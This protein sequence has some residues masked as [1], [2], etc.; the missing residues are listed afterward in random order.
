ML[1]QRRFLAIVGLAAL[2]VISA[3]V[4]S[5]GA[6]LPAKIPIVNIHLRDVPVKS[7]VDA[8]FKGTHLKYRVDSD[9]SGNIG[10]IRLKGIT[11]NHAIKDLAHIANLT[12]RTE[13]G[14]Y[15]IAPNNQVNLGVQRKAAP[16]TNQQ[17]PV[18]SGST[19]QVVYYGQ[20]PANNA[21][22]AYP[23]YYGPPAPQ[24]IQLGPGLQMMNSYGYGVSPIYQFG[25]QPVIQGP[26]GP[27]G[28]FGPY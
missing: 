15:I 22:P 26:F 20:L 21:A 1:T 19:T 10:E 12:V 9:V 3:Q 27:R 18:S 14:I 8:I 24:M 2:T 16:T 13:N 4:A 5:L 28:F 7:V 17:T 11:V 6:N 25:G 23:V